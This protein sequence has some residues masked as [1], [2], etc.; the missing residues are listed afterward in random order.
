MALLFQHS[1]ESARAT[2]NFQHPFVTDI[3]LMREERS[4]F[5]TDTVLGIGM[6]VVAGQSTCKAG[7]CLVSIASIFRPIVSINK[8][9]SVELLSR[10]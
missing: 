2:A 4:E 9:D 8:K 3:R 1:G 5:P 10:L 6:V 7:I